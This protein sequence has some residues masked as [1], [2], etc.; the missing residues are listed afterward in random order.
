M[1]SRARILAFGAAALAIVAGV[2]CAIVLDGVLRD[3]LALSFLL[4]GLGAIVL[5]AFLEVGLSEDRDRASDEA[6]LKERRAKLEGQK[7]RAAVRHDQRRLR[8]PRRP[9]R[10]S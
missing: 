3:V 4:A 6:R 1:P 5:L 7:A 10:P 9:R 2:I 8:L